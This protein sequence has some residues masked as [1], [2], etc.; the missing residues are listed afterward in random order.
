M[1]RSGAQDAS[2]SNAHPLRLVSAPDP[3]PTTEM[4]F[5][6]SKKKPWPGSLPWRAGGASLGCGEGGS[7]ERLTCI[8]HLLCARHDITLLPAIF[9]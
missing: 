6:C 3:D 9:L 5:L 8:V 4:L 2:T 1:S 7:R